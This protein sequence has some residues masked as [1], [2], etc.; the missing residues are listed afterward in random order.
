[1]H[2]DNRILNIN[3]TGIE[4]LRLAIQ[5]A[6]MQ[7]SSKT[8][9]GWSFNNEKGFIL[10]WSDPDHRFPTKLTA[11]RTTDLVWE[12]LQSEEAAT[13]DFDGWDEDT[14]HDGHNTMGWRV[15]CEDWG[16]VG[17]CRYAICAIRPV[18]VWHGK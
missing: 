15:Y 8:C 11:E 2:Y 3:G 4:A 9:P 16:H 14:D 13:V 10:H 12:W 6:F 1:M 5:I 18:Y 17:E 7:E